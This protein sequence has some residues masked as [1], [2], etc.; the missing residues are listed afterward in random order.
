MLENY[1]KYNKTIP[2]DLK[3]STLNYAKQRYLAIGNKN[4]HNSIITEFIT[5][6]KV[7]VITPLP[8]LEETDTFAY[9]PSITGNP[10]T[11]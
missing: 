1:L 10:T 7:T 4:G 6:K 3:N 9:V 5:K 2:E 8:N 11:N